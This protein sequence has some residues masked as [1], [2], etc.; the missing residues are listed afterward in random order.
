MKKYILG[1]VL[2]LGIIISPVFTHAA[3][4]T[5]SQ[6]QAILSLLSSFGADSATIANVNTALGGTTS[7]SSSTAFCHTFNTDLTVGSGGTEVYALNQALNLSGVGMDGNVS[8]SFN[9]DIASGVVAF[10]ARYGIRQTGYVGPITRAR[11][12]ALYGCS[13][14]PTPQP[15]TAVL[16]INSIS[17]SSL[18]AGQTTFTINGSGFQSGATVS[19]SGNSAGNYNAT[20]SASFVSSS[21]LSVTG[22]GLAQG[23]SYMLFVKN[24]NGQTSAGCSSY[25]SCS[26]TLPVAP[27]VTSVSAPTVSYISPSSATIGGT[28]YVYGTNF[29]QNTFVALDG[30]SG[31]SITP[32]LVSGTSLR[33]IIPTNTSIGTHTLAVNMMAGGFPLSSSVPLN[34]VAT[35]TNTATVPD[36]TINGASGGFSPIYTV[37]FGE[38][39]A[40]TWSVMPTNGTTCYAAGNGIDGGADAI[41]LSGAWTTPAL[42][43]NTTYGVRC[44][45][46]A[47]TTYKYVNISVPPQTTTATSNT[48]P[49]ITLNGNNSSSRLSINVEF[50][51]TATFTWGVTPTTGTSC[52]A[53]GIGVN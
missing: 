10:Q 34:V 45:N 33:F 15:N 28:V 3:G 38:T 52:S 23:S 43:T 21:Q 46:S 26:S 11:L 2:S 20:F 7:S 24:P 25:T 42:Y 49:T 13:N 14:Q 8:S 32:T 35:Q 17:P 48:A 1:A 50:G 18:P 27:A 4:L 16:S 19:Y 53:A 6:V 40:F 41:N 37:P 9:E 51:R 47:G 29:N 44:T 31:Q 30:S 5:D 12:N 36:I 22:T 39:I